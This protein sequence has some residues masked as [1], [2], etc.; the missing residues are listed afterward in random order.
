ML[1]IIDRAKIQ[2]QDNEI[3]KWQS[4]YKDYKYKDWVFDDLKIWIKHS[5]YDKETKSRI[6]NYIKIFETHLYRD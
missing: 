6:K 3:Q 4:E 5:S 1:D 2:S